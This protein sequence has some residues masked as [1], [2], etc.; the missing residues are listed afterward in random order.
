MVLRRYLWLALALLSTRAWADDP[1]WTY[2]KLEEVKKIEWKAAINGGEF[3]TEIECAARLDHREQDAL[4][5]E[6]ER[7]GAG[8]QAASGHAKGPPSVGRV[9]ARCNKLLRLRDTLDY[10][11]D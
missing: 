11:R 2:G 1:K 6:R 8:V 9:T 10:R 3:R 4:L 7:V 5:G